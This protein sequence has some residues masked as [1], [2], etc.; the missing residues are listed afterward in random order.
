MIEVGPLEILPE[1]HLARAS[2]R[3]LML[4]IRELRLLTELGPA[5]GSDH[6][7]RGAVPARLGAGDA[8]RGPVGRRVCPQAAREARGS[9]AGVA[10]HPHALRVRLPPGRR[11]RTRT[12]PVG[13]QLDNNWAA[14][15][16]RLR[17][18]P[19]EGDELETNV[20]ITAAAVAVAASLGVAACGSAATR[21]RAQLRAGGSS[22]RSSQLE[23]RVGRRSTAPARRSR[24]PIYRQWGS[25]LKGQ[26]LTVNFNAVGSGAGIAELQ[27][28]HG[29]L[30][31]LAT[32]R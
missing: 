29:R 14:G 28:R 7:A 1:E 32:R 24:R 9:A 30:R 20:Q 22:R 13:S 23:R 15:P 12:S 5:R 25:T 26:G 11:A 21:A 27:I 3:A 19:N 18:T 10:V 2:G 16:P 8:A 31:R 17:R 4:S 6:V